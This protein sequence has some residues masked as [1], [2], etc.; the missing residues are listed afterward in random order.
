MIVTRLEL[1]NFTC[2]ECFV[3]ELPKAGLVL[4][5][6]ANGSGK[7]SIVEAVSVAG[8]G[9]FLRGKSC[10]TDKPGQIVMETGGGALRI[11]RRRVNG[12]N[13][14]QFSLPSIE[15]KYDTAT[16][17]QEDLDT[18]VGSYEVWRRSSVLSSRDSAHFTEA[19]DADRKRLLESILGLDRLDAASVL[20]RED[21]R[22]CE[23]EV[24]GIEQKV[25][26][27]EQKVDLL[28]RQLREDQAELATLQVPKSPPVKIDELK[29]EKESLTSKILTLEEPIDD[30]QFSLGQKEKELELAKAHAVKLNQL[31]E[32]PTCHQLIAPS[33]KIDLINEASA[34]EATVTDTR[35]VLLRRR[36]NIK[37]KLDKTRQDLECVR[38]ALSDA[39]SINTMHAN[40]AHAKEHLSKRVESRV[41]ELESLTDE[42]DEIESKLHVRR[43]N[44]S[45]LSVVD[46]VLS[47]RGIRAHLLHNA[48]SFIESTA[49]YWLDRVAGKDLRLHLTPYAEKSGGGVK[50]QIG[51]EVEGA[52]GGHG[53][54]G[55]SGGE[56]RR[57][58]IALML[59]L[60]EV[61]RV[62]SGNLQPG[63]LF[64][65]EVLDAL[66]ADGV[67]A[68]CD[69]MHDLAQT[70][71]LV[72]ISHNEDVVRGLRN[73]H[74]HVRLG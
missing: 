51:L 54:K 42:Q 45:V 3:L 49:N 12:K 48:L 31:D 6:G 50:D 35:G 36:M 10:W 59:S 22:K 60:S 9:E 27:L 33:L 41:K 55:A 17:A 70:R 37:K 19:G 66:D 21:V 20:V 46:K 24:T 44:L 73:V 64:L 53:Y 38:T 74:E 61:A 62:S 71:C 15:A 43:H 16:K 13:S 18:Y 23:T 25:E 52:G 7:S 26:L 67:A 68:V 39:A 2:H 47:T 1:R 63:T 34:M 29:R 11:D 30:L 40:Y 5:T 14:L 72:I 56:R 28:S 8:W 57:I 4:V 32:C 65:D 69:V 58:D